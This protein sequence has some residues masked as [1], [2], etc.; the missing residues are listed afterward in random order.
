MMI[1]NKKRYTVLLF[2]AS[3]LL[4]ALASCDRSHYDLKMASDS[5]IYLTIRDV[6]RIYQG[7][8]IKLCKDIDKIYV[9]V[10]S[11]AAS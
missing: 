7:Q 1:M 5:G 8:D 3:G 2:I 9:T 10:I 4:A 11:D 6:K